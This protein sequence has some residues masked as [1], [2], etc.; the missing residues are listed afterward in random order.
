MEIQFDEI[1]L[2]FLN[3]AEKTTKSIYLDWP[4]WT[5]KTTL[6]NYFLS[7]TK[8]K[9]VLLWTTWTAAVNIGWQTI[10]RFFWIIPWSDINR[11]TSQNREILKK[12]DIVIIDEQWM[13]R[14]DMFDKIN[15][16]MQRVCWNTEYFWW[17]QIIW[18]WDLL[19]LWP[20]LENDEEIKEAYNKEYNWL[21]FFNAKTYKKELFEI[22]T[23]RQVRRQDPPPWAS[24]EKIK[25]AE[26]FKSMLLRLRIWDKSPDLLK[27]FNTKVVDEEMVNPKAILIA[28][29]NA[30]VN[31]KNELEL[32]KLPGEEKVSVAYIEWDYPID[33]FPTDKVIKMKVWARIMFVVNE[34]YWAY[35]NWTLWTILSINTNHSWYVQS[36]KIQT[37]DWKIL[38]ISK[39]IWINSSWDDE[40]WNPIIDWTFSQLPF[41]LAFAITIHKVQWKSFDHVVIDLWYWAFAEGQVYVALSRCRSY[42]WLQLLTP[43]KA[44]DIKVSNEVINFLKNE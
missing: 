42:E 5:W 35:V 23:L 19:Q 38:D 14:A 30:I 6:I 8:K 22:I 40:M 21:F 3:T 43:I 27:Y 13:K 33:S 15:F 4:W 11:M 24:I 1:W 12:T 36:V 32:K 37:D 7:K 2:H 18:V 16:L 25:E 31:K 20:I 17:K 39:Y 9:C 41:K 28:T 44:K 26:K 29:T 10:H 34:K